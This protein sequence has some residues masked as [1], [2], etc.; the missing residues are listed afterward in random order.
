MFSNSQEV[1]KHARK[2]ATD[3]EDLINE[4]EEMKNSNPGSSYT[5]GFVGNNEDESLED[6]VQA[7][8]L[9]FL[10]FQTSEMKKNVLDFPEIIGMDTTYNTNKHNMHLVAMQVIDNHGN[11]RV[12]AYILLRKE[13][14]DILQAGLETFAKANSEAMSSVRTVL[15]DKDYR[16]ISG[17]KN[18]LPHVHVHL[19]YTHV[20]RIFDRKIKGEQNVEELRKI[21]KQISVSESSEKFQELYEDLKG[22][23]STTFITYFDTYWKNI[24]SA[25]VLYVRNQSLSLGIRSTNHV[26]SHNGKIKSVVSRTNT[27]GDLV[28]GLLNLHKAR[29]IDSSYKDFRE[30]SSISYIAHNKDPNIKSIKEK[31]SDWG[32]SLLVE[33][34]NK[35]LKLDNVDENVTDTCSC[36]FFNMYGMEHCQHILYQRRLAGNSFFQYRRPL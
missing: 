12:A 36:N 18:V 4:L 33:E 26:E 8:P 6:D 5:I 30:K 34:Y 31:L 3:E 13:T 10:I 11:G 23:A 22:V 16:E 9:D 25:W 2:G 35:S 17:I 27:I 32:A 29:E 14:T 19:C 28:R 7:R 21:L 20:Q 1:N 24:D 15:V